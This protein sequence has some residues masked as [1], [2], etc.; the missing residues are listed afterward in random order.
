MHDFKLGTSRFVANNRFLGYFKI[1]TVTA[2]PGYSIPHPCAD[3]VVSFIYSKAL[4]FA[5]IQT[6][7]ENILIYISMRF[8]NTHGKRDYSG[9]YKSLQSVLL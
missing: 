7:Y 8:L 9:L 5:K 1:C 2:L 6:S 4:R 3:I